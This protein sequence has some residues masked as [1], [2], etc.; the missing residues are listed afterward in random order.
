MVQVVEYLP[1]KHEALSL[2]AILNKKTTRKKQ[3]TNVSHLH[4]P[5]SYFNVSR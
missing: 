3:G 4:L 5:F 2:I 1:S